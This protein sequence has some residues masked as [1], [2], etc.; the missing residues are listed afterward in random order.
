MM[1]CKSSSQL[2]IKKVCG[3]GSDRKW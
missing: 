3:E 2:T 1:L